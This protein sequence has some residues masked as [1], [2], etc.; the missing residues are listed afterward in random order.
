MSYICK[1]DVT[2]DNMKH[3]QIALNAW[4]YGTVV[5]EDVE[6]LKLSIANDIVVQVRG[7][8][9]RERGAGEAR[10]KGERDAPPPHSVFLVHS[11]LGVYARLYV[12]CE[13]IVVLE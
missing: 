8:M 4:N 12:Y 9:G 6:E 5:Q 1:V 2:S 10:N 13:L 11:V 7:T 3:A